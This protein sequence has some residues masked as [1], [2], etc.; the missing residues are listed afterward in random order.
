MAVSHPWANSTNRAG[1]RWGGDERKCVSQATGILLSAPASSIYVPWKREKPVIG[2]G[3]AQAQSSIAGFL[4]TLRPLG[5]ASYLCDTPRASDAVLASPL[6]SGFK[7]LFSSP[8][9][10]AAHTGSDFALIPPSNTC[11]SPPSPSLFTMQ[12]SS[13]LG[14]QLVRPLVVMLS[15]DTSKG[16]GFVCAVANFFLLRQQ[17]SSEGKPSELQN[18]D[19]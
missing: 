1:E 13:L 15:L 7:L 18:V 3:S 19:M 11:C 8:A 6:Q 10:A 5:L 2:K 14:V 4:V 12:D 9:E 17:L 16:A